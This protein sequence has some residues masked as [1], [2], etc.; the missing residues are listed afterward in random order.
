MN[1][2][3]LASR[4][5]IVGR[6]TRLPISATRHGP[7]IEGGLA[8]PLRGAVRRGQL[9][10]AVPVDEPGTV[11]HL[12]SVLMPSAAMTPPGLPLAWMTERRRRGFEQEA[13]VASAG[14]DSRKRRRLAVERV[15][16]KEFLRRSLARPA[17]HPQ[18]EKSERTPHRF[19]AHQNLLSEISLMLQIHLKPSWL[20][21]TSKR[22]TT[23]S[24]TRAR[25]PMP[26]L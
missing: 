11:Q 16:G 26:P 20:L 2:C 19:G 10:T 7:A 1:R 23:A 17:E 3:S 15:V 13:E 18:N 8:S 12:A 6:E 24:V 14:I 25:N 4:K 5:R 9:H 22:S 21:A